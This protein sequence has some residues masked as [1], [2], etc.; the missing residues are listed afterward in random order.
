MSQ[1][2]ALYNLL[3][4]DRVTSLT[5]IPVWISVQLE[6]AVYLIASYYPRVDF[7]LV[8]WDRG[9]LPAGPDADRDDAGIIP[10]SDNKP[11][12]WKRFE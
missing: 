5:V 12:M 8:C 3:R 7:I 1:L 9:Y 11:D 2:L 10:L 4:S 6:R